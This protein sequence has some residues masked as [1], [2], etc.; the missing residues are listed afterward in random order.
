MSSSNSLKRFAFGI[1][2]AALMSM[3]SALALAQRFGVGIG[4]L[5][6]RVNAAPFV[7]SIIV[8]GNVHLGSERALWIGVFVQWFAVGLI[9][10]LLVFRRESAQR[11][12][13]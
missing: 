7:V 13:A 11:V 12:A 2:F 4:N 8:S 1:A 3:L 9:F 10:S 5:A 6:A